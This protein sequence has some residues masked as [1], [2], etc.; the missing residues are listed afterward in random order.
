MATLPCGK[1]ARGV[2]HGAALLKGAVEKRQSSSLR[3]AE[4]WLTALSGRPGEPPPAHSVGAKASDGL[5]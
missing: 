3:L 2:F 4:D 5:T 1:F